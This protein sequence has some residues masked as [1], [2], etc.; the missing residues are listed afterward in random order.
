M[1]LPLPL[2]DCP[3]PQTSEFQ[4]ALYRDVQSLYRNSSLIL[5]SAPCEHIDD[6]Q[7]FTST[8]WSAWTAGTVNGKIYELPSNYSPSQVLAGT[9]SKIQHMTLEALQEHLD[10]K[11]SALDASGT[12]NFLSVIDSTDSALF[13]ASLGKIQS[14]DQSQITTASV[15]GLFFEHSMMLSFSRYQKIAEQPNFEKLLKTVKNVVARAE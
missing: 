10:E 3:L 13:L 2:G 4:R 11:L 1:H 6:P 7:K 5:L 9:A 8:E 14:P 12:V 15:G